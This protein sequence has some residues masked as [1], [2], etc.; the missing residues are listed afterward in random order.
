MYLDLGTWEW[1]ILKNKVMH[2]GMSYLDL[3]NSE[4]EILENNGNATAR[5]LG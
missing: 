3:D 1:G 5:Y 4:R 2:S